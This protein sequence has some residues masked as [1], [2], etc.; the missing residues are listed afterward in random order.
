MVV[1]D[2]GDLRM[3]GQNERD[4]CQDGKL[5]RIPRTVQVNLML[6]Q[7]KRREST[8]IMEYG[9]SPGCTRKA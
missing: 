1:E 4:D 5:D 8:K 6:N 7:Q 9:S 2:D 3:H